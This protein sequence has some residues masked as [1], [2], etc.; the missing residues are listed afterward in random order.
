MEENSVKHAS[1]KGVVM[2]N[3]YPKFGMREMGDNDILYEWNGTELVDVINNR[4]SFELINNSIIEQGGLSAQ[5]VP[6]GSAVRVRTGNFIY[7]KHRLVLP[8]GF[9][10]YSLA[11]Y[12]QETKTF[13]SVLYPNTRIVDFGIDNYVVKLSISK[14]DTTANIKPEEEFKYCPN[15]GARMEG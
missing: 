9:V 6:I 8:E 12:E 10:V 1:L 5:G 4:I 14:V 7:G 2:Q 15:C 11:Y 13:D 3:Y